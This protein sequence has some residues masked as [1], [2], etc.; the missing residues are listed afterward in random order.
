MRYIVF[1]LHCTFI[2]VYYLCRMSSRRKER[3]EGISFPSNITTTPAQSAIAHSHYLEQ[4][5]EQR[6]VC[7][8]MSIM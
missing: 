7:T 8:Q 3:K 6:N 5:A 2:H 1:V 4:I